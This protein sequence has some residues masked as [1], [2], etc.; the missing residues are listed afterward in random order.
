MEANA[1]GQKRPPN[2]PENAPCP[3]DADL[4][5]I[6]AAWPRLP[7]AVRQSILMLVK[8]ASK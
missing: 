5:V 2:A 3:E 7:E 4:T 6:N 1:S 8:A